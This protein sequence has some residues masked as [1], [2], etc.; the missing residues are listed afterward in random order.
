MTG[1]ND[2]G[3]IVEYSMLANYSTIGLLPPANGIDISYKARVQSGGQWRAI[4]GVQFV[5]VEAASDVH[6]ND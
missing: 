3:Q 6:L 5:V 4:R 1:I 2:L